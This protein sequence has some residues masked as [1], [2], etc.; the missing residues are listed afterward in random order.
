M[1]KVVFQEPN[2]KI[3]ACWE[4][5]TT[6]WVTVFPYILT[7]DA[8][9][10]L[11]QKIRQGLLHL[12]ITNPHICFYPYSCSVC[13]PL[14][15]KESLPLWSISPC[16]WHPVTSPLQGI[17]STIL[18]SFLQ[19]LWFFSSGCFHWHMDKLV[20]SILK[21]LMAIA[22][23]TNCLHP[24]APSVSGSLPCPS[25]HQNFVKHESVQSSH[26]HHLSLWSTLSFTL[27]STE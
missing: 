8:H 27:P 17:T 14:T 19:P 3:S 9:S 18:S 16:S 4:V 7:D 13:S 26:P 21:K 20:F 2:K 23:K 5:M 10:Y 24:S 25:S 15:R 11:T 6:C 12:L 22:M 1:Y